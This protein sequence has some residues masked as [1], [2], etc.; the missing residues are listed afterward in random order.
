MARADLLVINASQLVTLAGPARARRGR[1]MLRLRPIEK[2]AIAVRDGRIVGVGKTPVMKR[3]FDAA[4]TLDVEGRAIVP[5]F[6]DAHTHLPFAGTRAFELEMK[7][8]GKGYLD[9]L[10]AGGG[11]HRTV[12]DT[13]AASLRELVRL[14]NLR[15]DIMLRHGTTTAEA[16]SGYGLTL[17]D[18]IKQLRAI[19]M[20]NEAQ[21]VDLVPTLLAAHVVPTEYGRKRADYV[22]LVTRKLIPRVAREKLAEFCDAFLESNAFTLEECAEI[23]TAARRAGLKTKLH[24]DEFTNQ[25]GAELAAQLGC[26]SAEHLLQVSKRGIKALA[27][28]RTIA[29]L[30]PGVTITSFLGQFAPARRMVDAGV[31]V[32]LGTDFNPNCPV[33]SM[34]SVIQFAVY[35]LR[36]RPAEALTAAT[37]NAAYAVGRGQEVGSL[38]VG[39]RADFSVLEGPDPV[40]IV[41]TLGVNPVWWVA[42]S[43]QF[44][45]TSNLAKPLTGS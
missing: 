26:T 17:E 22:R 9:I 41:Y 8:D 6:V 18:E 21:P 39:K 27:E 12:R 23:L 37:I 11:I 13:R 25:A 32:A 16:K 20:A 19:A 24:A 28:A 38:E 40:D 14:L 29:V 1:E 34:P 45:D 3:R 42:K 7:L 2:G 31:P 15:L 44:H 5:G 35:Q 36:L 33:L 30:L 4:Q 10:R 43:G